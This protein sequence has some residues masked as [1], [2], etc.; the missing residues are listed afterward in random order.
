MAACHVAGPKGWQMRLRRTAQN[1]KY[2]YVAMV[3]RAP[4]RWD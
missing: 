2:R 1:Y 4:S 3:Q